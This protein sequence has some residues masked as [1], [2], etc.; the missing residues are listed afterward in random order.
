MKLASQI[1]LNL[2]AIFETIYS[3]GGVTH[4]ARHL[5]LSQPAVSHSLAR[6]REALGDKLFV[7]SGNA[8]VPTALARTMIVPVREAL[9]NVEKAFA[10][11]IIFDPATSTRAFA[12]GLRQSGE[13]RNFPGLVVDALR[14]APGVTIASVSFRRR[15]LARTLAEGRLDLALDIRNPDQ[16]GLCRERLRRDGLMVVA[17]PG[18][19]RIAG[20]IDLETYLALDHI[21]ASPRPAG[22]GTEDIALAALGL[23]RRIAVRCQH[24]WSAWQIVSTS[25]MICTLPASYAATMN[26]V[27]E[28]QLVELPLDAA[29]NS[30]FMH[31]H[32]SADRDPANRWLRDI[33][34]R[35]LAAP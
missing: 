31:W 33:V 32:E 34:R 20:R 14:E 16:D 11:A 18:H 5:N 12:I 10:T 19:P 22:L 1:D 9:Q 21:V 8:L 30:L 15:D 29:P 2:L 17:R 25:D 24:A 4:A 7:R 23:S 35:H 27:A 26:R 28:N 13:M 3:Q 6:L